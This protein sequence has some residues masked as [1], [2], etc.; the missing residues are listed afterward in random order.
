MTNGFNKHYKHPYP[1]TAG[2]IKTKKARVL[3]TL[4]QCQCKLILLLSAWPWGLCIHWTT[5]WLLD[6]D[7]D[8]SFDQLGVRGPI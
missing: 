1:D 3:R 7:C 4:S 6:C 2:K 8:H 5:N